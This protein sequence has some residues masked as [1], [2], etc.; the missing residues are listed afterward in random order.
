MVQIVDFKQAKEQQEL[1][2]RKLDP[3]RQALVK[4]IADQY[5]EWGPKEIEELHQDLDLWG[6]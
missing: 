6:E 1:E 2:R 3:K 4:R 5:P